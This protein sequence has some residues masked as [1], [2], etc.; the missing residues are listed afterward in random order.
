MPLALLRSFRCPE[1]KKVRDTDISPVMFVKGARERGLS[2]QF[3][4]IAGGWFFAKFLFVTK[5]TSFVY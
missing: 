3:V 2:S 1:T 5:K 4:K